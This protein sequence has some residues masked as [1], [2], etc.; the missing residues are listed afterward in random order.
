MDLMFMLE[1]LLELQ[2]RE[3]L[4]DIYNICNNIS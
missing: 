2:K 3:R 1:K 4:L